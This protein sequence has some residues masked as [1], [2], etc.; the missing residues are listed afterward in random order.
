MGWFKQKLHTICWS[1]TVVKLREELILRLYQMESLVVVMPTYQIILAP[2][3]L[4]QSLEARLLLRQ[5]DLRQEILR[6]RHHQYLPQA[7]LH[8]YPRRLPFRLNQH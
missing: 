8:P 3:Q 5:V 7:M 6:S 4:R 1:N 2:S